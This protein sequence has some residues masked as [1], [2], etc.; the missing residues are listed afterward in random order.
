MCP[1]DSHFV[2]LGT[3]RD[4]DRG[5]GPVSQDGGDGSRA[6]RPAAA[7]N[8]FVLLIVGFAL[9]GTMLIVESVFMFVIAA[10]VTG[11]WSPD[12][13]DPAKMR[14]AALLGSILVIAWAIFIGWIRFGSA[15]RRKQEQL[16]ESFTGRKQL[17]VLAVPLVVITTVIVLGANIAARSNICGG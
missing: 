15:K 3:N 9:A 7:P 6:N 8:L 1:E 5:G 14:Q 10:S 4:R 2:D 13:C 11:A 17:V 12:D 16:P